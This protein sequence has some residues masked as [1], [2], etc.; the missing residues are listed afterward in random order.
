[1]RCI[2][3]RVYLVMRDPMRAM[4][5]LDKALA[6]KPD[7]PVLLKRLYGLAERRTATRGP[8]LIRSQDCRGRTLQSKTVL[9]SA[10]RWPT[11]TA[12]LDEALSLIQ[13]NSSEF[14]EEPSRLAERFAW[15]LQAEER[16]PILADHAGKQVA[17][18]SQRL[19]VS[20]GP[21]GKFSWARVRPDKGSRMLLEGRV[22]IRERFVPAVP[23]RSI[24]CARFSST[25]LF[26][27]CDELCGLRPIQQ[28]ADTANTL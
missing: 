12:K 25:R 14:L 8:L 10:A 6:G 1:M 21:G 7:D 16:P 17:R 2:S 5:E 19:A 11:M 15:A 22:A 9:N 28:L 13:E 20:H 18:R 24:A 4:E 27:G 3:Q 26:D 23:A